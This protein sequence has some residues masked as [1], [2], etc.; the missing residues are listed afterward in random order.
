MGGWA[1]TWWWQGRRAQSEAMHNR[2]SRNPAEMRGSSFALEELPV[3]P[4]EV[5]RMLQA[6]PRD[7]EVYFARRGPFV[8][9]GCTRNLKS[10]LSALTAYRD[11][12]GNVGP[13][14]LLFTLPGGRVTE[15][16]WHHRFRDSSVDG[17]GEWFHADADVLGF[18]LLMLQCDRAAEGRPESVA[19]LREKV[20]A[21]QGVD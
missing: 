20:A 9:I 7:A 1:L 17:Y 18:T 4:G 5:L 15:G 16:Y 10:R 6:E 3:N 2:A 12:D 13:M 8:K 19:W 14:Q 11:P 21:L